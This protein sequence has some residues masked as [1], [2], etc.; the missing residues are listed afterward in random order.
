MN[1]ERPLSPAAAERRARATRRFRTEAVALR[2]VWRESVL[3]Q[4][5][6][7]T[8]GWWTAAVDSLTRAIA[9]T[10]DPQPA[11]VRLGRARAA[12]GVGIDDTVADLS[13]LYRALPEGEPPDH[14]LEVLVGAW[15]EVTLVPEHTAP[16]VEALPRLRD[17]DELQVVL[18]EIARH[19]QLTGTPLGNR[20]VLLVADLTAVPPPTRC[21]GTSPKPTDEQPTEYDVSA[22]PDLSAV[23]EQPVLGVELATRFRT[24]FPAGEPIIRLWPGGYVVLTDASAELVGRTASLRRGLAEIGLATARLWYED[25]PDDVP[26]AQAL[27]Q[28]LI[29]N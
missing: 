27:Y 19:A 12:A 18:K 13:A 7:W 11:C 16:C 8:G 24:A 28:R 6:S 2:E 3:R 10:R 29:R 20:H 26:A 1:D 14:L 4:R 21:A 25:F 9:E 17:V 5:P 22:P 23:L 15:T